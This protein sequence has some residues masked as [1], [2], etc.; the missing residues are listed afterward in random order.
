VT[1]D[2][3]RPLGEWLRQRR[4]EL[5]IS[6]EQA[7]ADTRIRLQ[8]LEAL[9]AENFE[10]LPDQVVGRGF[11]RNY[12]AYL[13]LDPSEAGERYT[14]IVAPPEPEILTAEEPSPFDSG[15]FRPLALHEIR[16][17]RSGRWLL[18]GL[19][20]ILAVAIGLLAWWWG[21]PHVS[22]WS[23]RGNSDAEPTP[24]RHVAQLPTATQTAT[25]AVAETSAPE[26]TAATETTPTLEP[27]ITPTF[28][29]QPT[30]TPSPPVYT[31]IFLELVFTDT[32]WIQ[33]TVDGV[34][35]FQG[36]LDVD[37]YRSWYGEDRIELRVGNAGAVQITLNGQ[38]L[39]T[40]GGVGEVTDR[41]FEKM[42]D[43]VTEATVTPVVT[44]T[45]T[46]EPTLEPTAA[47]ATTVAPA[48]EITPTLTVV[49]PAPEISPTVTIT[50]TEGS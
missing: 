27:T 3:G 32:S 22:D 11:L 28:T 41:V 48:A 7:E 17:R 2:N 19:L 16:D 47:P 31:G 39:G 23:N 36:E 43:A 35:Q 6:L 42:G 30:L 26:A 40:L 25:V 8:Y 20:V 14:A 29:P 12:A 10:A 4:E 45:V 1:E 21:Y 24:T 37:T 18:T 9:E 15:P 50:P 34:R 44:G 46:V 13:E 33:V 38:N 5:E 49:P